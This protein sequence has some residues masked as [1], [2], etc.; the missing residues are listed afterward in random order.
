M[1]NACMLLKQV[2][3]RLKHLDSRIEMKANMAGELQ[4]GAEVVCLCL[5][6]SVGVSARV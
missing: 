3:D 4:L 5:C 2:T 1:P 6:R